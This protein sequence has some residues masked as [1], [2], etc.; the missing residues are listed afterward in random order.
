M[1][2]LALIFTVLAS[3]VVAEDYKAGDLAIVHPHSF[4]T[5]GRTGAGYMEIMN[6]GQEDRLISATSDMPRTELHT[7]VVTDGVAKMMKQEFIAIPEG[8]TVIFKPKGLHVMFMGL[9][10]AWAV[11][12]S[13]PVTL[14][15]EKAGQI[16]IDFTVEERPATTE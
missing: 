15:F 13:I 11:G 8:E 5:I 7:T 3:S 16:E 6:T 2:L 12:D 14:T 9:P 4:P 1:R 10:N